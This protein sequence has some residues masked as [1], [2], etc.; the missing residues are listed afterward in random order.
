MDNTM[1]DILLMQFLKKKGVISERDMHEFHELTSASMVGE[2]VYLTKTS[3]TAYQSADHI[4]ELKA[5]K[6][7]SEMYHIESGR[8]YVGE[9][10]DMYKAR[11]V[12]ERYRGSI[13]ATVTVYDMYLAINSQYHDYVE[14]FRSWFG[15]DV[16]HKIIESAIVF[17]FKDPD[18]K[19]ENKVA[20]YFEG[21]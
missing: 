3:E 21:H 20:E 1:E 5:K 2:P 8:K 17:W 15:D 11:E 6:L 10:F 4:G 9:K 7:V 12:C 16:E 13:P 19:V 18:S 14:L